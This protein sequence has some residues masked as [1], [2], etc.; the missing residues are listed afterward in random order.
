MNLE[1]STVNVNLAWRK[2]VVPWMVSLVLAAGLFARAQ[3]TND[4]STADYSDYQVIVQRNIFDPNRFPRTGSY[5]P[6]RERGAPTFSLAGTMSYRKGMFAFFSGTSEEYQKALQQGGTIAGYTVTKIDFNGVQL[7]N[8][9]KQVHMTVGSAMRQEGDG[10]V[11]SM[12]GE[13]S[14]TTVADTTGSSTGTDTNANTSETSAPSL[15]SGGAGSDVLKR[16][17]QQRQQAEQQK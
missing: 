17:M 2:T 11:L 3:S 13:W 10:W 5:R 4:S 8:A 16:L 9:G 12:P 1:S 14:G 6:P 15:P 7:Q